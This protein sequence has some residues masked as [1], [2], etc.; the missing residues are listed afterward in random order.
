MERFAH[1]FLEPGALVRHPTRIDWGLGQVQLV[2]GRKVTVNFEQA[3]K[4]TVDVV[5][6]SL[7]FVGEDPREPRTNWIKPP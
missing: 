3:G 7:V 1:P 5:V 4:Q 6:V 2:A